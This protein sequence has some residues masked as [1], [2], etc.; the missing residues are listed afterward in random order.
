LPINFAKGG[1]SLAKGQLEGKTL[2]LRI[3]D[4]PKAKLCFGL[5]PNQSPD[6]VM[7]LP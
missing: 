4:L 3:K 7:A 1:E 2:L 5:R 6:D